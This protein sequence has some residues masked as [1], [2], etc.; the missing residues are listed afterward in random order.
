[1]HPADSIDKMSTARIGIISDTHGDLHPVVR[2]LFREV[3]VI[4]H[5][6]DV[7]GHGVTE[8]LRAIAPLHAVA[9]NC[10]SYEVNPG[11]PGFDLFRVAGTTIALIHNINKLLIDP[12]A[13]GVQVVVYGHSHIAAVE[14]LDGVLY[15]NPGSA[16]P[17]RFGRPRSVAILNINASVIDAEIVEFAG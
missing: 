12:V 9:G 16:G 10:D 17:P 13:S 14:R 6:G 1:M 11:L 2:V 15:V 5:A 7:C 3:D 8:G 4:I